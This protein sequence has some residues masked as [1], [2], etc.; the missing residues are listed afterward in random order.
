M[1]KEGGEN[2]TGQIT[3]GL[4]V[5]FFCVCFKTTKKEERDENRSVKIS[6][7]KQKHEM[8]I[9]GKSIKRES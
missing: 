9:L 7:R 8:E 1:E 4:K 6:K 3:F 2:K 5:T